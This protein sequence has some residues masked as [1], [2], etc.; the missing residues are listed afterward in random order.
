MK[1]RVDKNMKVQI[2]CLLK[3][4]KFHKKELH[5]LSFAFKSML[6]LTL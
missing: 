4:A 5:L 3:I 2:R 1:T 6:N